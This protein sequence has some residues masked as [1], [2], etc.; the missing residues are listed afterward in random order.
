LIA[1]QRRI[2]EPLKS[3]PS[4][5]TCVVSASAAPFASWRF[6]PEGQAKNVVPGEPHIDLMEKR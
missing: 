1:F 5:K 3:S 6:R 4:S 2:L